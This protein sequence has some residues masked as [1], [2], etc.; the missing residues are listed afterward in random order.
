MI[1]INEKEG[2]LFKTVVATPK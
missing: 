2:L 1:K